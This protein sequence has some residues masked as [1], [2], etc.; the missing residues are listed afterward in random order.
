MAAGVC[1]SALGLI[2]LIGWHARIGAFVRMG[3]FFEPMVYNTA[4][5]FLMFGLALIAAAYKFRPASLAAGSLTAALAAVSLGQDL[6]GSN[7]GIDQLLF[8]DWLPFEAFP[9]GRMAP[10]T[11]FCFLLAAGAVMFA[12]LASRNRHRPLV[13]G[14]LGSIVASIGCAALF[15]WLVGM[16]YLGQWGNLRPMAANAAA[17]FIVIGLS[18]V[19]AGWKENRAAAAVLAGAGIFVA[20]LYVGQILRSVEYTHIGQSIELTAARVRNEINAEAHSRL[21]ALSRMGRRWEVH[22]SQS[23]HEWLSDASFYLRD[24]GGLR[25][26]GWV[27]SKHRLQ[28]SAPAGTS[29]LLHLDLNSQ[30]QTALAAPDAERR[31]T[32]SRPVP[33]S[34]HGK[35]FIALIPI[36]PKGKFQGVIVGVFAFED[37]LDPILRNTVAG[38]FSVSISEGGEEVY[39]NYAGPAEA[40][41]WTN[42]IGLNLFGAA[43]RVKVWPKAQWLSGRRTSLPRI[44]IAVG[45]VIAVLVSLSTYLA[46][47]TRRRAQEL[48]REI[49][50]RK[51]VQEELARARDELEARVRE[52][53][54]ELAEANEEL[55]AEILE[56]RRAEETL[57]ASEERYRSLFDSAN[58]LVYTHDLNGNFTSINKAAER[59]TGLSREDALKMNLADIVAPEHLELAR[60]MIERKLGGEGPTTYELAILTRDRGR[61]IVEVSTHLLFHEGTPVGTLGIAREV[62]ERK[63]LEEQLRHSQKI[64]AIGRLAGGIAHDFNN[65]LTIIGAYTHMLLTD[66]PQDH[67]TLAYAQEI[68]AA[69]ERASALTDRLLAFSRR[70][71]VQP[72]ILDLNQLIENMSGILHRMIGED[73]ELITKLAPG[74]GR[75]K[76]D[77]TQ[78][79]QVIMNLAVNSRDA[80]PSGGK[81]VLETANTDACA[82]NGVEKKGA[83]VM[84]AVRD[85][86]QGMDAETL[87]HLFEPFF[88]T[89]GPGRGTGLG[90]SIVYGIV[91]QS[92]GEIAVRSEPGQ[93]SSFTVYLPRVEAGEAGTVFVSDDRPAPTG[94]ETILL[95]EDEPGVRKLVRKML[96]QQGYEV[97][98]ASSGSDALR[99]AQ[100]YHGEIAMLL[101]DIVMPQMSGRELAERLST[102]RPGLKVLYMTGYTEDA[103][104]RH[105]M[106][107]SGVVCLQKPFGPES[108]ARKVREVLDAPRNQ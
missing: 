47:T 23:K 48:E 99:L 35:G 74:L 38:D 3:P 93:G 46:Q 79:E 95:V 67:P 98:E 81:L 103:I 89:K 65:L 60:Q 11:S 7:L 13:Q 94:T 36:F 21:M 63:R 75:V 10:N 52:R 105:G 55:K 34:P 106:T 32:L 96:V 72:K 26:L 51:Q 18:L 92:G 80:M 43:W 29:D 25:A 68:L 85:T 56:R 62:T 27:D 84:L 69:A 82:L 8:E 45:L 20:G 33:L 30:K 91:K 64:E 49:A 31:I 14:V 28:W 2:T 12:G 53:T 6:T 78:L 66:L 59:I 42:A 19:L 16:V 41:E 54:A 107:T 73:I 61:V 9:P 4:V 50:E 39:R 87:S 40:T 83:Y 70:Q 71:V 102:L 57:R 24:L 108:L 104:V 101:T 58:D 97:L 88:T 100:E 44:V 5:G 76:A 17:G 37:L 1:S 22:G 15:A 90:L 86:G 77:P